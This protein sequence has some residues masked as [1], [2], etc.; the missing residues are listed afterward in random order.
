MTYLDKLR[1]EHPE[2]SDE[3]IAEHVRLWCPIDPTTEVCVQCPQQGMRIPRGDH[4]AICRA[5][6]QMELPP[7][8]NSTDSALDAESERND[9]G[10]RELFGLPESEKG[11]RGSDDMTA[12]REGAIL[13]A[14]LEA[15]GETAQAIKAL[16]ELSEL[17]AL[18]AKWA[19]GGVASAGFDFRNDA[20]AI[21]HKN[22]T[23][24]LSNSARGAEF[25]RN[26]PD[27][28]ELCGSP[29][30]DKGIWGSDNA[31]RR[32]DPEMLRAEI[33]EEM[34][35]AY[36]MLGQMELIF[37]DVAEEEEAKLRRLEADVKKAQGA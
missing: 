33:R 28:R 13:E 2:W 20:S 29:E 6:W 32:P 23:A 19:C 27:P 24:L 8:T 25:G 14:A 31:P 34:A 17:Q 26:D 12:E 7:H 37:G 21:A 36:I 30:S 4:R 10:S 9:P 35:D 3:Q 18:L 16:E 15:W 11:I 1:A 22:R 5:C